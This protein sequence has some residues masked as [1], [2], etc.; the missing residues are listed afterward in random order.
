MKIAEITRTMW[1]PAIAEAL[2]GVEFWPGAAKENLD[3]NMIYQ[4]LM[5][6]RSPFDFDNCNSFLDSHECMNV[7]KHVERQCPAMKD[8]YRVC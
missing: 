1:E 6:T 3:N 8:I 7:H 5:K 4:T 2:P